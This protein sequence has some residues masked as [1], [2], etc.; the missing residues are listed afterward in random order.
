MHDLAIRNGTVVDGTGKTRFIGDVAIDGQRISAVGKG[1]GPAR[2]DIDADGHL[3]TPGWVDVHT[4]LDGQAS[5]DP[6]LTPGANQGTTTAI[7]GNCGVGFAPCKPDER[8]MLIS[9]M[10]DVEDIPGTA[11]HEGITWEWESFP[12]YMDSLAR[13]RRTIDIGAQVPH[14]AVRCYVMGE[15][16][17]DHSAATPED[18]DK[19]RAI[20]RGGIEAGAIG[21][22]T[23]RTKLHV[24]RDGNTMPGTYAD[25]D[26][27]LGIGQALAEAGKG[28]YGLVSDFD[29][30]KPEMDWMRRLSVDAGCTVNFV[31]FF[32]RESDFSRVEEQL[33]YVARANAEGARLVPHV[34]ARP[35]NILMGFNATVHPF[36]L[37]QNFAPL[38]ELSPTER[39]ARLRDPATRAA[40]LAEEWP[41]EETLSKVDAGTGVLH[42]ILHRFDMHYVLGDPP[43]YEPTPE[44]S[45]AAIAK[46]QG[47]SPREV[48]YDTML[49]RD[50]TELVYHPNFG[51]DTGDLSRQLQMMKDPHSVVSLADTGA[52]CGVLCDATVPSY[53][54]SWLVRDRDRGERLS[55]EWAVKSHTQDT[56]RCVGLE[57]RGIIAPGMK[58]DLNVIDFEKLQL[59]RP[60]VI[61]DLPAGGKRIYQGVRGYRATVVSGLPIFE[62]GEHT[63]ELPGALIRGAQPAPVAH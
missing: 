44:R 28:V 62:N 42:N 63:G 23:S 39:I 59:E 48:L 61:Y 16:G 35:V 37:H 6:L 32:R 9:V 24:T 58:A 13:R 2:R 7:M 55:L 3:V 18:I 21:F 10:E 46:R 38:A 1:C 47:R 17:S 60:Q 33:A 36:M 50:G 22:T 14:C 49:E 51:Y 54:L 20:V 30:W 43:I 40:L 41:A 31:L 53:L 4:H 11:L 19:M 52:H 45:I 34:G 15:R 29:D 25:E 56:A 12:D 26:E 57:D 27:L 5:W 8:D